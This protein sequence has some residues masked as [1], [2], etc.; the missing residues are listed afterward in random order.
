MPGTFPIVTGIAASPGRT[1]GFSYLSGKFGVTPWRAIATNTPKTPYPSN[2]TAPSET[3]VLWVAPGGCIVAGNPPDGLGYSGY[4]FQPRGGN[5]RGAGS[6][7]MC[8]WRDANA[9]VGA[10]SSGIGSAV[11]GGY[12]PVASG[13]R[14]MVLA[15]YACSAT[16]TDSVAGCQGTQATGT[17]SAAFGTGPNASGAGGFAIGFGPGPTGGYAGGANKAG[18]FSTGASN[19]TGGTAFIWNSNILHLSG[20]TTNATPLT[21]LIGN[22]V[23]GGNQRPTIGSGLVWRCTIEVL[24]VKSDGT[25]V[26]KYSRKALL[27]NVGGTTTLVGSVETI[28]TDYEDD[29]TT[30]V[31]VTADDTNDA[32]QVNVTGPASGTWRWSASVQFNELPYGA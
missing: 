15:G 19:R 2:S 28:G 10:V 22:G 1:K 20:I 29:S 5:Q 21:L 6:V 23:T 26:S 30:D 31:D 8:L 3:F 14:A 25:Q 7:D 11:I 17:A 4:T 18:M 16:G 32:L 24:G 27:K 13:T 9:G 12:A